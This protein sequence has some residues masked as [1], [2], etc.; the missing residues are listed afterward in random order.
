[1][2]RIGRMRL[3]YEALARCLRLGRNRR[4][5]RVIETDEDKLSQ[6]VS[7]LVEGK[8]MPSCPEGDAAE[9]VDA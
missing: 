5:I 2:K 9:T 8:D 4:I 1:M 3:T 7:V 6:H